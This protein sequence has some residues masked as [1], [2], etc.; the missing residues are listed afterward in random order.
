[1]DNLGIEPTTLEGWITWALKFD[2]QWRQR[3]ESK[4]L[5]TH[6][7]PAT[8]FSKPFKSFQAS[9]S[10]SKPSHQLEHSQKPD[11]IPME[12]DSGWKSVKPPVCFKCRKPGHKAADCKSK[13]N[14]NSM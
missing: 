14:I 13:Y 3:E 5:F 9:T 4:R 6:I 11:V 1:M 8:S 10:G 12:V 7:K 2:R